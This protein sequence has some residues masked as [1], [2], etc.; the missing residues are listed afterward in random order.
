MFIQ[1]RISQE[2]TYEWLA[3]IFRLEMF[4]TLENF[5]INININMLITTAKF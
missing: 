1:V 4:A 3:S 2:G 5:F